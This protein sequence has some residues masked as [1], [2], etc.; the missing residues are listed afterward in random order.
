MNKNKGF[1][2]IGLILAIVLGIVVVGGGA[3]Y[4]GKSGAKQ[5]VNN[6]EN[7]LPNNQNQNLPINNTQQVNTTTSTAPSI[8]VLSPNGGE[9]YIPGKTYDITWKSTDV[10]NVSIWLAR[11]GASDVAELITGSSFIPSSLGKYSWT[12]PTTNNDINSGG[13]FKVVVSDKNS[14]PSD[15]SDN[16]F[17]I[18]S[19]TTAGNIIKQTGCG[20]SFSKTSDWSVISNTS[21]ETALDILPNDHTG[22]SGIDIKCVLGNSITDTDAKFGNITYFYDTNKKAWMETDN[23]EGEGITSHSIPVVATPLFTVN[24]LP[25]FRGTGRW[26]TYIIPISQSSILYLNEGDTEGGSTQS[27][28]N[29]VKTLKKL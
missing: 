11:K 29:L 28:T 19:A 2:G 4:L 18:N 20:V 9:S 10:N 8:T 22:F 24:G 7:I 17:T 25:V 3:Y 14:I 27:L 5:S 1:I 26:L 6:L 12:I 23:E 16:Y 13:Q 21:N 15:S